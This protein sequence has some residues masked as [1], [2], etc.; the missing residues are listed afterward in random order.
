MSRDDIIRKAQEA[1]SKYM[2]WANRDDPWCKE[3]ASSYY[4]QEAVA[5]AAAAAAAAEREACADEAD[6][7]IGFDKT[8]SQA[9][10]EI[11]AAIRARGQ[12]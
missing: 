3:H 1:Y 2:E 11:A 4:E 7:W 12:A 5:R 6:C 10:V 9:C 8:A